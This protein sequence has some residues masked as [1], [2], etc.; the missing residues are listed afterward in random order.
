MRTQSR[1]VWIRSGV[2][3]G[4][5]C[6]GSSCVPFASASARIPAAA[7]AA[8]AQAVTS[9]GSPRRGTPLILAADE[10]ERRVR[11]TLGERW[12]GVTTGGQSIFRGQRA[13]RFATQGP[14]LAKGAT[15]GHRARFLTVVAA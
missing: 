3:L 11:R 1:S 10:G 12:A 2:I 7:R 6:I 4:L 8:D 13:S 9:P 15:D 14:V 5:I